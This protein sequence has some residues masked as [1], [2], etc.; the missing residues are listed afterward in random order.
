MV[1]DPSCLKE[2]G[3]EPEDKYLYRVT[4]TAPVYATDYGWIERIVD[5]FRSRTNLPPELRQQVES[6]ILAQGWKKNPGIIN[7]YISPDGLYYSLADVLN[8]KYAKNYWNGVPTEPCKD[9][10]L[11]MSF[12]IDEDVSDLL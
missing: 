5:V 1:R 10:Y 2:L 11:T 4:P 8:E 12:R 9:E 6:E 3:L 7:S